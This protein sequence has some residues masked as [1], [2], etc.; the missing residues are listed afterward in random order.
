MSTDSHRC[1]KAKEHCYKLE[2]FSAIKMGIGKMEIHK[3]T[4]KNFNF[5]LFVQSLMKDSAS[6]HQCTTAAA[7]SE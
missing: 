5:L 1:K 6:Y 7:D 3:K 4:L 2:L